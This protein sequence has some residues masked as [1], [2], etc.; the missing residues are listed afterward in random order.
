[1]LYF[2]YGPA[3][4]KSVETTKLRIM[5]DASSEATKNSVSLNDCL[6]IGPPLQNSMRDIL[7]RSRF[8][9]ILL[10]DDIKK[11]FIQIKIR[12]V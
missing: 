10:C 3:I 12:G 7:V 11:V 4:R 9:P 5:Y 6:E 2:L 1:M 8:K